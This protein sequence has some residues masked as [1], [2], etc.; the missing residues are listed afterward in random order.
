MAIKEITIKKYLTLVLHSLTAGITLFYQKTA[1]LRKWRLK[2][3]AP[4]D[5]NFK[6]CLMEA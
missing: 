6:T 2:I 1:F 4:L 5:D 3:V